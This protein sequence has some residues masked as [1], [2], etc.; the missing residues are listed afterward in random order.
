MR[1]VRDES[2]FNQGWSGGLSTDV[3]T[4]RRCD[5]LISRMAPAPAR[6]V[7][8]IGCGR[9]EIARQIARKTGMRVVGLDRSPRFV[10]EARSKVGTESAEFVVGDFTRPDD[11][12]NER[13]DYIVGNG[14]LH[15]LYHDLNP[16]L[17]AMRKL[18][19]DDG[20]IVFLEPNL[21]NPYVFL[22]FSVRPLRRVF[23]LEPDEMAF[24]RRFAMR[25]LVDA[26]FTDIE[27]EYRDFL[28]PGVPAW[29]IRPLVELGDVA[30]RTPG[31][32]HLSQSLFISAR[33]AG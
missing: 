12:E 21:H 24:S 8:E 19:T 18:L 16:S 28:I 3:R 1:S 31:V 22:I 29:M 2:G 25:H 32:R 23:R 15:H 27:V 6:S 13:F 20:R 9:G 17:L 7:L 5:L 26:G 30:E 33:P 14:I 10:D 4:E 11:L